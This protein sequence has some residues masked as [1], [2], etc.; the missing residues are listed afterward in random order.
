MPITKL[1]LE[2][3]CK[4]SWELGYILGVICGDGFIRQQHYVCLTTTNKEFALAFNNVL[5]RWSGVKPY[6]YEY[7]R[8]IKGKPYH[9]YYAG[10]ASKTAVAILR[11]IGQFGTYTWN[12]PDIVSH[13]RDMTKGFLSGWFDS[14]GNISNCYLHRKIRGFS[15]NKAGLLQVKQLLAMFK[16]ESYVGLFMKQNSKVWTDN[17]RPYY[18]IAFEGREKLIKFKDTVTFQRQTMTEKLAKL[19]Q[20]YRNMDVEDG[21][22]KG[23]LSCW[24]NEGEINKGV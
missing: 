6:L 19:L 23:L 18:Y 17:P 2:S 9:Y 4:E 21:R 13:N 1:V 8:A 14:E 15:V 11:N 20:S 10:I 7:D 3:A 22:M 24:H 5:Q 12:I 16:I